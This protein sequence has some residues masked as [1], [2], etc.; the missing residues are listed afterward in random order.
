M[1][2]TTGERLQKIRQELLFE[3][4]VVLAEMRNDTNK[5]TPYYRSLL[6]SLESIIRQIK[7]AHI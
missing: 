3:A 6:G 1:D 5:T 2:L 7:D 4:E